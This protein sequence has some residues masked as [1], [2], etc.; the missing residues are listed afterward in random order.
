MELPNTWPTFFGQSANCNTIVRLFWRSTE[1][2]SNRLVDSGNLQSIS[3]TA[4]AFA[5]LGHCHPNTFF[6]SL[7]NESIVQVEQESNNK[8]QHIINLCYAFAIL[9]LMKRSEYEETFRKLWSSRLDVQKLSVEEKSQLSL[10]FAF[11]TASGMEFLEPPFT[12][13]SEPA[14]ARHFCD[15]NLQSSAQKEVSLILNE[16]GFDH[17]EEVSPFLQKDYD[18]L[19]SFSGMLAIDMACRKQ[20]VAIEFDGPFRFLREVDSGKVLEIENGATNAKRRFLERLGWK[21][22]NIR[23]FDWMTPK[24]KLEKKALVLAIF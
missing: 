22:V 7:C 3:N 8:E 4:L 20:M 2:Y 15:E 21:V 9:D 11:A 17:D 6:D 12:S 24:N 1:K 16:L 18:S 19:F 13:C 5:K 10:V 23:Y 14:D